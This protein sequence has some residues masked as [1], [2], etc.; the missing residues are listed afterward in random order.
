MAR[1][2]VAVVTG[3]GRGIGAAT[4]RADL[5]GKR[6]LAHAVSKAALNSFAQQVAAEAGAHGISVNTVAPGAVRTD[7]SD[8]FMAPEMSRSGRR[9]PRR[10]GRRAVTPVVS[11]NGLWWFPTNNYGP[12]TSGTTWRRRAGV[13][14]VGADAC[15]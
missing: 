13:E 3:A 15:S 6:Q 8:R 2:P 9:R 12:A 14:K 4:S 10:G 7:A 5:I 1:K 11:A